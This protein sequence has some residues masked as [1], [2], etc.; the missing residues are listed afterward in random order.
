MHITLTSQKQLLS[1]IFHLSLRLLIIQILRRS[2][3]RGTRNNRNPSFVVFEQFNAEQ[4][5]ISILEII[6]LCFYNFNLQ[7]INCCLM[8][9]LMFN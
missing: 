1:V 5:G 6:L 9:N 7:L 8:F 2:G 4:D 3:S